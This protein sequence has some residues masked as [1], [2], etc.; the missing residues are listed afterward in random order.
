M[1][2]CPRKLKPKVLFVAP[3][4][5]AQASEEQYA[6]YT[7]FAPDQGLRRRSVSKMP[8]NVKLVGQLV[9]LVK[10]GEIC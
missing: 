10:N 6:R 9:L 2:R 3:T 4:S 5:P 1:M 7:L 8:P